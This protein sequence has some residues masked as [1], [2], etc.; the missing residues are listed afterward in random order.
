MVPVTGFDDMSLRALY[1]LGSKG[2]W[3]N[4]V[5]LKMIFTTSTDKSIG[6]GAWQLQPA[7]GILNI[8]PGNKGSFTLGIDYRFSI[9][10]NKY[11]NSSISVLG[12][13]PNIDYWADKFYIGYYPTFTYNFKNAVWSFPID[14]EAGYRIL[15]QCWLSFEYIIPIEKNKPFKNEFGIKLRVDVLKGRKKV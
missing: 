13:A 12:I 11:Q 3:F 4:G 1:I 15:K 8:F 5:G 9:G 7:Y 6:S 14:V 2:R 10:G